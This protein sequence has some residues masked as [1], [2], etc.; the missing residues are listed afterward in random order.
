MGGEITKTK[1]F[2][3]LLW[4]LMER[5]GAYGIQFIVMIILARLLLPEDFGLIVLVTTFITIAGIFV[6]VGFST[7]LIQKKYADEEDYSSVFYL[8]L[9]AASILYILIFFISP[10][11]AS[12]Y[13]E[14]KLISVLRVLSI[15]LFLGAIT[16]IQNVLISRTMQFKKLFFS[17]LWAVVISGSIGITLAYLN[18]GVWALVVQSLTSQLIVTV[19]LWF[20]VDWRPRLLFSVRKIL[21]LLPFSWKLLVSGLIATLSINLQSL[22]VGKVF[23]QAMLGFYNRGEQLP[24]LFV[25]NIDGAIQSVMFPTLASYQDNKRKMKDIVRRSIVTSSFI[26]F[27]LMVGLAVIAEPLIIVL[28]TE[29]WLPAVPFVQIFCASYALWPIHTVNLQA[30]NALGRSDIFLTLEIIKSIFGLIILG[31][32][33]QFGIYMIAFG[34]FVS[35]IIASFINSYPNLKLLNYSFG[36]QLKDIIPSLLLALI[37]GIVIYPIHWFG[38][39]DIVTIIIQITTGIIVYVALAKLSNL[40]CFTYLIQT[41]KDMLKQKGKKK[42]IYENEMS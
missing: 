11:I 21:E 31:I 33:I 34:V 38:M 41:I 30:I 5:G 9:F 36:E 28:F 40:E 18:F 35:G 27:P 32:S 20:T 26:I 37:M 3:S 22:I 39:P 4:K 13:E 24:K 23:S 12:F 8:S 17:S 25:T 7:A 2:S 42:I 19:I 1:V 16:S 10:Y 14:P 6:Q 29:K 15:M